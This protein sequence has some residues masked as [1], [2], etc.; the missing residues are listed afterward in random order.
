MLE[1][2]GN[3]VLPAT[4]VRRWNSVESKIEGLASDVTLQVA[5]NAAGVSSV[6]ASASRWNWGDI[7]QLAADHRLSALIA[8]VVLAL[9][10]W[11]APRLAQ[12]SRFANGNA[13]KA[14]SIICFFERLRQATR[15]GDARGPISHCWNGCA[16]EP[17]APLYSVEALKAAARDS[18]LDLQLN[19]IEHELFAPDRGDAA[20]SPRELLRRV[21]AARRNLRRRAVG[22]ARTS[23]PGQLN[24][25]QGQRASARGRRMPA[26]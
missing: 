11:F 10:A 2:P 1:K 17:T 12:A 4:D 26:R 23:L 16:F 25:T 14:G 9:L 8:L 21:S 20:W 24:P 22:G 19:S 5:A 6:G 13:A 7:V 3:Y 18:A 15:R